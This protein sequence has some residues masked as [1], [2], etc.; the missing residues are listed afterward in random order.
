MQRHGHCTDKGRETRARDSVQVPILGLE[1]RPPTGGWH[2]PGPG[3]RTF[4]MTSKYWRSRFSGPLMTM[5]PMP[6]PAV[7]YKPLDEGAIL[8]HTE[9]KVYFGLN[10]VGAHIW[11]LLPPRCIALDQLCGELRQGYPEA[12]PGRLWDDV[13]ELLDDLISY[14]LIR[15][16]MRRDGLRAG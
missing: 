1:A 10:P 4:F 2:A 7:V 12:D 6:H 8:L 3:S 15:P 16:Q 13:V 9:Q 11:E 5:L 14:D